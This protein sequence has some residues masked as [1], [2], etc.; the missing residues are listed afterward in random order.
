MPKTLSQFIAEKRKEFEKKFLRMMSIE[1]EMKC[2]LWIATS[3]TELARSMA[4]SVK[5][6]SKT[7]CANEN[8]GSVHEI[9]CDGYNKAIDTLNAKITTFLSEGVKST[10]QDSLE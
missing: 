9:A 1:A 8:T 3:L 6:E 10:K 5:M 7:C 2:E 4:E